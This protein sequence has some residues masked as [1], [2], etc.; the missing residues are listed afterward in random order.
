MN[1][2][3]FF[4]LF[5]T[6]ATTLSDDVENAEFIPPMAGVTAN[7]LI[8]RPGGDKVLLSQ[9][10]ETELECIYEN[11]EFGKALVWRKYFPG[12]KAEEVT[13]INRGK[14]IL[15]PFESTGRFD[16]RE[17][18]Y[19]KAFNQI[20]I[21]KNVRAEDAGWYACEIFGGDENSRQKKLIVVIIPI[22][23]VELTFE[24]QF[25]ET[26]ATNTVVKLIEG[27][28][29]K[30][31]CSVRDV[32]PR[33]QFQMT[34][35]NTDV[36][37]YF[38][39]GFE[40]FV[41]EGQGPLHIQLFTKVIKSKPETFIADRSYHN[42]IMT[43]RASVDGETYISSSRLIQVLSSPKVVKCDPVWATK[44]S[45]DLP[46]EC[47][48]ESN[49]KP[50]IQWN[51][52]DILLNAN[53][54][55]NEYSTV[56]QNLENDRYKAILTIKKLNEARDIKISITN[57]V[58]TLEEIITIFTQDGERKNFMEDDASKNYLRGSRI[59]NSGDGIS[60]ISLTHMI[61]FLLVI[62]TIRR[63]LMNF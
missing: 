7:T 48:F 62:L 25:I 53:D 31:N 28:E 46:V 37:K 40:N 41:T 14:K 47:I 24:N 61:T 29:M 39:N 8:V 19:E 26:N 10:D 9:G 33:P 6:V 51:I 30:T 21:I 1:F 13:D 32:Y 56:L 63:L 54:A 4:I 22:Q 3:S 55:R 34:I 52:D 18:F 17:E 27:K 50:I 38:N 45:E 35:G 16:I 60:S 59:I 23:S 20:L 57:D 12:N 43:C 42:K 11:P 5:C 49:T 2:L 44:G 58:S 36:M 15:E